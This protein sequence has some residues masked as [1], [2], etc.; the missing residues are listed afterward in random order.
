[1]AVIATYQQMVEGLE[2]ALNGMAGA[3]KVSRNPGARSP[4]IEPPAGPK[5]LW[6]VDLGRVSRHVLA[7]IPGSARTMHAGKSTQLVV[8][9]WYPKSGD[10]NS[11]ATWRDMLDS[12]LTT[13]EQRAGIGIPGILLEDGPHVAVDGFAWRTSN[14][15]G[16]TPVL[17][18]FA[19]ILV[20]YYQEYPFTT[21]D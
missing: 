5:F 14:H 16:D 12:A 1:M 19:R 21:L 4:W 17:C 18:H 11:A 20:T 13:L 10:L 2:S 7:S 15:Q 8:E 9:A 3:G 6:E